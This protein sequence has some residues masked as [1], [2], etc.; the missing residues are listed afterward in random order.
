[1]S[2][3]RKQHAILYFLSEV[4]QEAGLEELHYRQSKQAVFSGKIGVVK[5]EPQSPNPAAKEFLWNPEAL[6]KFEIDKIILGPKILQALAR[7]EDKI[8]WCV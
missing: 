3:L 2:K 6:T 8:E 7:P 1:M 4:L 5:F